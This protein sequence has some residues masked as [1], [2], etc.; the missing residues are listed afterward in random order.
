MLSDGPC[1]VGLVVVVHTEST[2]F[3][4]DAPGLPSRENEVIDYGNERRV[5]LP[6]HRCCRCYRCV[7]TRDTVPPRQK[8]ERDIIFIG[9]PP[10]VPTVNVLAELAARKDMKR[11]LPRTYLSRTPVLFLSTLKGSSSLPHTLTT[12]EGFALALLTLAFMLP[13]PPLPDVDLLPYCDA[14]PIS[15]AKK[16]KM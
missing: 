6:P 4:K 8:R 12:H 13:P 2:N 9:T 16:K 7:K 1:V 11:Q 3:S 10:S 5:R 15:P 14:T